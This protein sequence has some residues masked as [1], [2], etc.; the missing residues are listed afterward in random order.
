MQ[1]YLNF[2]PFNYT[3]LKISVKF[4][5]RSLEMTPPVKA[6][7][8]WPWWKLSSDLWPEGH[9]Q[10]RLPVPYFSTC[11][12]DTAFGVGNGCRCK[13]GGDGVSMPAFQHRSGKR[14]RE[15]NKGSREYPV[16]RSCRKC[17]TREKPQH[18]IGLPA[19]TLLVHRWVSAW[20]GGNEDTVGQL[21][22]GILTRCQGKKTFCVEACRGPPWS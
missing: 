2:A 22:V 4:E 12:Q 20:V 13:D 16:N 11:W 18:L 8:K 1:S 14:N 17:P 10:V 7:G 21:V 5:Y 15:S 9:L 19:N 6:L 3:L